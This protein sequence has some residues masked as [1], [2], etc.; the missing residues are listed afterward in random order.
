MLR[1]RN[2]GI[3]LYGDFISEDGESC[4]H[5]H[6]T[7]R[8]HSVAESYCEGRQGEI[9][10]KVPELVYVSKKTDVLPYA[11][12]KKPDV[13]FDLSEEI[14]NFCQCH[15]ISEERTWR[16]NC[17]AELPFICKY[18]SITV[19]SHCQEWKQPS[20][21]G[22]RVHDDPKTWEEA[23]LHCLEEGGDLAKID[24][25]DQN[26]F[27]HNSVSNFPTWFGAKKVNDGG[28]RW[29]DGSAVGDYHPPDS[30]HYRRSEIFTAW[31]SD[32]DLSRNGSCL[33]IFVKKWAPVDC[34]RKLPYVCRKDI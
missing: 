30:Y 33:T 10:S 28:F 16:T 4:F 19:R 15:T 17:K 20:G 3:C 24:N 13:D 22:I 27:I 32:T 5:Y 26:S 12:W 31:H 7:K 18:P 25:A 23:R 1:L 29:T 34:N 21:Y 8:S 9:V 11:V 6:P 2:T 14:A